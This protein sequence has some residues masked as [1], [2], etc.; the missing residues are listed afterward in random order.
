MIWKLIILVKTGMV[1]LGKL[2]NPLIL[3]YFA[4]SLSLFNDRSDVLELFMKLVAFMMLFFNSMIH[5]TSYFCCKG[6]T[7]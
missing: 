5:T 3:E 4:I 1:S 7:T 6:E 2:K